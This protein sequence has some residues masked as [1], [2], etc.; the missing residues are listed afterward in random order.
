MKIELNFKHVFQVYIS[1]C[2]E[3]VSMK[4]NDI[5]LNV[6]FSA[7]LILILFQ[8][9]LYTISTNLVMEGIYKK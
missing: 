8:T 7:K 9:K 2:G 5:S 3:C 6:P 1:L 4:K